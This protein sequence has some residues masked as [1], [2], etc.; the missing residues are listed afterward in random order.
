M[1]FNNKFSQSLHC[2]TPSLHQWSHIVRKRKT[3]DQRKKKHTID[4]KLKRK[5]KH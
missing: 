2:S 3:K 5:W 4:N 1:T